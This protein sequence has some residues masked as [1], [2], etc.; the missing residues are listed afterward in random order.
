MTGLLLLNK[1]CEQGEETMAQLMMLP[2]PTI[3]EDFTEVVFSDLHSGGDASDAAERSSDQPL[4]SASET[5]GRVRYE[6]Q[7]IGPK[8]VSR[9]CTDASLV[10]QAAAGDERAFEQL[11]QRYER[12]VSQFVYHMVY[13]EDAQDIVQFVFLQL[14]LYLPRLQGR[15]VST[16]CQQPLK[17][18]LM[19]VARNRCHDEYRKK[20][21]CV[22][23]EFEIEIEEE[24]SPFEFFP[25]TD[26]LPED[27]VEL[28]DQ[29]HL[30]QAAIRALP[31]HFRSI[32]SLRYQEDLSFREIGS[33]LNIPENTAKTYFQRARPLLRTALTCLGL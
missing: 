14:Y 31:S 24:I 32:V 19:Q 22:F 1:W 13:T 33:R 25:D 18:W 15:L 12:Q 11:V 5:A 21:P 16:R 26:P 28:W 4:R 20:H 6:P 9:D 29:Q 8:S 3:Q 23:S 10:E 27:Y 30:L 7:Q 17:S 2:I